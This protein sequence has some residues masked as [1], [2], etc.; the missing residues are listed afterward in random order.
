ME[1]EKLSAVPFTIS[2]EELRRRI[3]ADGG[4]RLSTRVRGAAARATDEV[5]ERADAAGIYRVVSVE[6]IDGTIHLD[7]EIPLESERLTEVLTPCD[8]AAVFLA[9]IGPEIDQAIEQC[10]EDQPHYGCVLDA[11]AS[12]A[13]E[14]VAKFV[15]EEIDERL[16]DGLRTTLRYSPGYCDWPLDA[17]QAL[18]EVL[19]SEEIGV[20]LSD[21]CLM[22]PRKTV[23]GIIGICPTGLTRTSGSACRECPK[24]SCPHRRT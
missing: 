12:A 7:G 6:K 8:E 11:A 13:A 19:P 2:Q 4:S 18:F 3:G 14:S 1:F 24:T 15:Q 5:R 23:S 9:T 17:Q 20:E 10:M 21:D 22:S 16:D